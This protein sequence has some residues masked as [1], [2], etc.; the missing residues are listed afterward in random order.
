MIVVSNTSVII[1][2]ATIQQ[3]ELLHKL[4][5]RVIIP[6]AVFDEIAV[7]GQG[8]PGAY[9]VQNAGWIETKQVQNHAILESILDQELD[10]GESEAIALAIELK[11]DRILI[12]ESL[13]R[14]LATQLNLQPIGIL[15]ILLEA[16]HFGHIKAVRPYMD[17]LISEA[18]FF[19]HASLYQRV[20]SLANE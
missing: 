10:P 7:T 1:N 6:K 17:R 8:L 4:F 3:L 20:V 13:G 18:R 2:L 5:G 19:I 11:A 9:E 16:K 12:D 14:T 15:G